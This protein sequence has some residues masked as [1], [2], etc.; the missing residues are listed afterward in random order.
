MS[1]TTGALIPGATVTLTETATHD[2][3]TT[4]TGLRRRY[5]FPSV[6]PGDYVLEAVSSGFK[7][8]RRTGLKLEV[9]Q[10]ARWI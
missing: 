9:N 10:N 8:Q 5:L 7:V 3:R 6:P 2:R 1:D 4:M